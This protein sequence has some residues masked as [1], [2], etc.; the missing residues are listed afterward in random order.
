MRPFSTGELAPSRIRD[1]R[2]S[3][4]DGAGAGDPAA[5]KSPWTPCPVFFLTHPTAGNV[6]VDTGLPA[7]AAH[8]LRAAFGRVGARVINARAAASQPLA[9]RLRELELRPSDIGTVV[10]THLH[11]DHAGSIAELPAATFVLSKSEW[12]SAN[13]S[14][15]LMRGYVK[16]QFNYGFDYRLVDYNAREITSF[17]T[18]GRSFDLFGDG[19]IRLVSTPGHTAGHQSVVVR[20]RDRE[21]LLCGDAAYT[22]RTI[23]HGLVPHHMQDEHNFRRSLREIRAYAQMT[24]SALLVPGHDAEEFARLDDFYG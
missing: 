15:A 22:R 19:S 14:R 16:R 1:T 9:S 18:F 12:E 23:D 7:A 5:R 11:L 8:D 24:P 17:A 6:L 10:L 21:A 3:H 13:A 2:E 20:L 4:P